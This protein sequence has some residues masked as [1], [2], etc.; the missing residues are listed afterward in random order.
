MSFFYNHLL[1]FTFF[2]PLASACFIFFIRQTNFCAWLVSFFG[3]FVSFIASLFLIFFFDKNT[4]LL[5]FVEIY[6]WGSLFKL[7]Y[8][9]GVDG[10]SLFFIVLTSFLMPFCLFLQWSF[11]EEK[12]KEYLIAFLLLE[13]FVLN[14]FVVFNIFLFFIFFES[15]LLPM[16]LVVGLWGSRVRKIYAAYQLVLYTLAGSVFFFLGL[17]FIFFHTGS[18]DYFF[19]KQISFSSERQAFLW[20]CFFFGFAVKVPVFPFHIWLPEAHVEAPTAGSLILA[21]ILLKLGTYGFIRFSVPMFPQATL[22]FIPLVYLLSLL[23]IVYTSLTTLRQIDLK[24]IIAYSSVAHMGFVMLGMFSLTSTSLEGAIFLMLSHGIVSSALFLCVGVVYDRYKTRIFK[25]YSGLVQTMPNFI[26]AFLFFSLANLSFPGTSSF[27]G[28]LLIFFGVFQ[29]SSLAAFFAGAGSILGAAY[30]IW[31]FNR[32]AY[33]LVKVNYLTMFSDLSI[34]EVFLFMP[35]FFFCIFFG[36]KAHF[37][38]DFF[39]FSVTA[40]YFSI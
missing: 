26:F 36:F 39:H 17:L 31:I 19:L 33:G 29:I 1:F 6:Y 40:F 8:L 9:V 13:F 25:Y 38:L 34:R 16:F 18:F 28:E 37:V 14:V 11:F 5:Q 24:K 4:G 23:G 7:Q 20:L 32:V 3:M 15:V 30:T 2:S 10:I 35:L 21:G 27:V 22:F 12:G